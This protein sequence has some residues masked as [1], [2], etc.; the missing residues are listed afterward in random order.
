M[1]FFY[2]IISQAKFSKLIFSVNAY[3]IS[4]ILKMPWTTHFL[5]VNN[6]NLVTIICEWLL[7][8]T[9]IHITLTT[10]SHWVVIYLSGQTI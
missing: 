6:I 2:L 5:I 1:P 9:I 10:N 8:T 4:Q 7:S 3:F